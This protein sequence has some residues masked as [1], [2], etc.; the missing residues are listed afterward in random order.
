MPAKSLGV[1]GPKKGKTKYGPDSTP[2]TLKV[3]PKSSFSDTRPILAA[4]S[5]KPSIPTVE[6]IINRDVDTPAFLNSPCNT[7]FTAVIGIP[8]LF[9][10]Y[11]TLF[12]TNSG[13]MALYVTAIGLKISLS[14]IILN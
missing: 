3:C 4:G 6:L 8:K 5:K 9:N 10:E 11:V 12:R 14:K 7:L 1:E 13:T 2:H